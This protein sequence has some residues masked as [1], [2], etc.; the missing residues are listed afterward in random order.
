M[1]RGAERTGGDRGRGDLR[2]LREERLRTD[3]EFREVVRKGERTGT[4]HFTVYRD[5]LGGT[6]RKVGISVGKRA[7]CAVA[8]NRLKRILREFYRTHKGDF[9][10][11]S[12][13]AIVARKALALPGL[14]VVGAELLSAISRRWGRKEER[15]GCGPEISS[16]AP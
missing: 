10:P 4:E 12:R 8:R 9:P 15:T 3:R 11:G 7:G 14:A 13:T 5:F 16:S 1:T 6:A 2:Y